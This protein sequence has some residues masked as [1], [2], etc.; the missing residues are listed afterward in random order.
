MFLML[1]NAV[2]ESDCRKKKQNMT[3]SYVL[4]SSGTET[5]SHLASHMAMV[6]KSREI[7]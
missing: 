6:Q 4:R 3:H 7:V 2:F 1:F 5:Y